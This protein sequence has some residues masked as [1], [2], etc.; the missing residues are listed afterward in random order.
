MYLP[1][2]SR[3]SVHML[4]VLTASSAPVLAQ[5]A[6]PVVEG[7][8]RSH[9]EAI[10]GPTR[11]TAGAVIAR[12]A[13]SRDTDKQQQFGVN[14]VLVVDGGSNSGLAVGQS[15]TV[16]RQFPVSDPARADRV[17]FPGEHAAGW[18]RLSRVEPEWSEATVVY[19]CSEI[20]VGDQLHVFEA[21]TLVADPGGSPDYEVA[22]SIV[23]GD[24]GRTIG[25]PTQLMVIDRGAD[26]SLRIGQRVTLFRQLRGAQGPRSVLG[27][28]T[29]V[30]I[31]SDSATVRLD[32][33]RGAVQIGDSAAPHTTR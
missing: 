4:V 26:H 19:Q 7:L 13:G 27:E 6:A 3:H 17:Q 18:V 21:P 10:C 24:E 8:S 22:A 2:F 33:S 16:R 25:G 11:P 20:V 32:S 5:T 12:I 31:A 29:I 9:V 23:F 28:G 1:R 15:L 14:D 30:A